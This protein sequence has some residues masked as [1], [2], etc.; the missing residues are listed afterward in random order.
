MNARTGAAESVQSEPVRQGS[1]PAAPAVP[2]QVAG[3]ERESL[4]GVGGGAGDGGSAGARDDDPA[5]APARPEDFACAADASAVQNLLRCWVRENDLPRPA[6]DL[7]RLTLDATGIVLHVPVHHWSPVG[8]HRFGLPRPQG[9]SPD[10]APLDAVTLAALIAREA[11]HRGGGEADAEGKAGP[12]V[13]R[14]G[15][16]L[17]EAAGLVARV[18]DSVQRTGDFLAERAAAPEVP[19]GTSPFL[20]G[21]QSLVLGHPLHPTPKSREGLSEAESFAYSPELRG[22]LPAALDGRRPLGARGRLR[23]DGTRP[24]RQRRTA[25]RAPRAGT[26]SPRRLPSGTVPLPLHPWQARRAPAPARAV[27]LC[28]PRACCTTWGSPESCGTRPRPCVPSHRPTRPTMLKLS[29]GLRITNSRRENLRKE[30]LRGRRGAPAAARR[31]RRAV[32][33]RAPR[34]RHR[35]R[36]RLARRRRTRRRAPPRARHGRPAQPVRR[37]RR[38]RLRGTASP[39]RDPGRERGGGCC[40]RGSRTSSSGL[41]AGRPGPRAAVAT[42]VVPALPRRRRTA[43]ALA[44]RTRRHRPGGAPAEHRRAA[45]RASAGPSVDGTGTTRATT[46]ATSRREELEARLPGVGLGIASD[47]FVADAVTDERFA[48][49]LGIN[50]VLGLIGA[51]GE[52]HLADERLLLAASPPLPARADEA[53][54]RAR[55]HPRFPRCCW[56]RPRCAAR[57][58][59]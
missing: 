33:C 34:L 40:A 10:A 2:A 8:L 11:A 15:A 38:R 57:R 17:A 53:R 44:G 24:D 12:P 42:R 1:D 3:P 16:G 41:P 39:R 50:N 18:A 49:Y 25:R 52:Q 22:R 55:P 35:P 48:Y 20:D 30:L 26:R 37:H 5:P 29:L 28:S 45:G 59:C 4:T 9:A 23:L 7:L 54:S 14:D 51:F 27:R 6:Q 47:S 56:S 31:S 21:E 58:T 19:P 36:P 46:S 32:A 43:R 13:R